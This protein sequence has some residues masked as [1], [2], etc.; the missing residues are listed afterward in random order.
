MF[1]I[2]LT[3]SELLVEVSEEDHLY[4]LL[5]GLWYK[6]A[7]GYPKMTSKPYQLLH[8]IVANR[9]GLSS[10]MEVDH[11]DRNKLNAKRNNLRSVND[12]EQKINTPIQS[13]NTSGHKGISWHCVKLRWEVRVQRNKKIVNVGSYKT[14]DEAVRQRNAFI[15]RHNI[16]FVE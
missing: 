5:L 9:M 7:K 6:D 12:S 1:F 8:L 2:P 15:K 10:L 14:L 11:S 3:N 16:I 4:L 13:N